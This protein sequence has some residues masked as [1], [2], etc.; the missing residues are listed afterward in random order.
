MTTN[1]LF[2]GEKSYLSLLISQINTI[3]FKHFD[4]NFRVLKKSKY[5]KTIK[6]LLNQLNDVNA[7]FLETEASHPYTMKLASTLSLD[8]I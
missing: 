4:F 3:L 8:F 7:I 2:L 6:Y 1:I 5:Y